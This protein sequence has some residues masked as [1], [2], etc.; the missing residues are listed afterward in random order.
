[1]FE[2]YIPNLPP[3]ANF[4]YTPESP[5]T[6]DIIQFIDTSIDSDGI[7]VSWYWDF[8]DGTNSTEQNT[9]HKYADDGN[10]YVYL[11]I[12]DDDG[13]TDTDAV[14][15]TVKEKKEEKKPWYLIPA[16]ET[17]TLIVSLIGVYILL[18]RRR[19]GL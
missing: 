15:I 12:T 8:G 5:T 19:K 7:I 10:Y 13:A 16:F 14:T 2:I 6:A 17:T 9:T 11:T 18:L 3:T 4:T 1:M